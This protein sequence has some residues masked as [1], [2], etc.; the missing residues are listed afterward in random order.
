MH[1]TFTQPKSLEKNVEARGTGAVEQRS[2]VG[3]HVATLQEL[4]GNRVLDAKAIRNAVFN[5]FHS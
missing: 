2:H 3:G 4:A 5:P 1:S